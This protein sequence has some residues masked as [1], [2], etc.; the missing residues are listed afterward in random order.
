MHYYLAPVITVRYQQR[1]ELFDYLCISPVAAQTHAS[2]YT[3]PGFFQRNLQLHQAAPRRATFACPLPG[4]KASSHG[5]QL[6]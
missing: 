6:A 2:A 3:R 4:A 5:W 1:G